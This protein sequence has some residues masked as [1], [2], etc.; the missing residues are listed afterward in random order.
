MCVDESLINLEYACTEEYQPVCGC[1]GN[2]YS[3]SFQAF[4]FYGVIAYAE[5]PCN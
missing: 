4:N 1:N 5:G 3:N 2:T